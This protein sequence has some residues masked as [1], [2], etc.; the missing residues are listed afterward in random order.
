MLNRSTPHHRPVPS[1]RSFMW[2]ECAAHRR[3]NAISCNQEVAT[4]G[5]TLARTV[6][7]EECRGDTT[8]VLREIDQLMSNMNMILAD[9]CLRCVV[10]HALQLAAVNRILWVVIA[11]VEA[12]QLVPDFLAE[13][14]GI[15][16]L[17]GANRDTLKRLE[18]AEFCEFP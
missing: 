18:E 2:I 16:Q 14:V 7:P 13:S 11:C 17:I 15:D 9:A 12:A 5:H 10:E 6:A 1:G 4:C 3:M 8:P